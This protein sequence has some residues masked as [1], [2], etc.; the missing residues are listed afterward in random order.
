MRL[1][2][3]SAAHAEEYPHVDHQTEPKADS[4]IQI[5]DR[6][7]ANRRVRGGISRALLGADI[8][9]DGPGK[10]EEEEQCSTDELA[11]HCHEVCRIPLAT[12]P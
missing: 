11:E 7:K 8:S 4:N 9:N 3:Q 1:T 10:G 2:E 6:T 12:R 5:D